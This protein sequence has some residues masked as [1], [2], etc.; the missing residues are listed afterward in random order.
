MFTG[1]VQAV[2]RVARIAPAERGYRPAWAATAQ[3]QPGQPEGPADAGVVQIDIDPGAWQHRP[4]LGDSIAVAGCCLTVARLGGGVWGFDA[5]P[6]TLAL[7]RLGS[8]RPGDRVNLEPALRVGSALGGHLVQGHVDGVA[9]V[10]FSGVEHASPGDSPAGGHRLRLR[11]PRHRVAGPPASPPAPSLAEWAV[12]RG[13]VCIE[14]VSLTVAELDVAS[15]LLGVALIPST[16]AATTLGELRPGDSVN[17][18][19]DAAT[20]A[21]VQTV[22]AV[23]A[24]MAGPGGTLAGVP[25][26]AP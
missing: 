24:Q 21:V 11:L 26:R 10:T 8:L 18:E 14:G 9:T 4:A 19:M 6:Q 2:G 16:L 17:V 22:R 7:T 5:V 15:G 13:S 12:P 25:G 1:L 23:L 3:G 20:K